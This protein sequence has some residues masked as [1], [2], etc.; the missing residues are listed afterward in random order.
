MKKLLLILFLP[1]LFV[2]ASE[3]NTSQVKIKQ[4]NNVWLKTYS[5]YK[6]YNIILNNIIKVEQ[7]LQ[8]IK[9]KNSIV[10]I[11]EL[12]NKVLIYKSKLT[13]YEKNNSFDELIKDYKYELR[14]ITIYDF[15]F[16]ISLQELKK[17]IIKYEIL[18]KEFYDA[19]IFLQESYKKS[20]D[21]LENRKKVQLLQEEI[22]YF[23][24]Y[25]ENVEKMNQNLLEQEDEVK[26][27]YD[28]YKNEVF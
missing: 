17:K 14:D 12:N 28:E 8:N 21:S 24:E 16:S 22:E 27:K 1:I 15:L 19:S 5:N 3:E 10:K 4:I 18:K 9:N 2:F 11:Q 25:T 20:K 23:S 13:L 7:D 6:N 26:R